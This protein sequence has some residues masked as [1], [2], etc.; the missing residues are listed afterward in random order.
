MSPI[1]C[2]I[3][4]TA[5]H[6][7]GADERASEGQEEAERGRV[8]TGGRKRTKETVPRRDPCAV[9]VRCR[10]CGR[11]RRPLC[12]RVRCRVLVV[13]AVVPAGQF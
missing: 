3:L 10:G 2:A 11:V 8:A 6:G 13:P 5:E 1:S 12:R 4:A 7:G 9:G